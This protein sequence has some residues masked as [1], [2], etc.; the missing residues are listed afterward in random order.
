MKF[1]LILIPIGIS[2]VMAGGLIG[3][4]VFGTKGNNAQADA[5]PQWWRDRNRPRPLPSTSPT[6]SPDDGRGSLPQSGSIYA[7]SVF[8]KVTSVNSWNEVAF[9]PN[10]DGEF[11]TPIDGKIRHNDEGCYVVE[12]RREIYQFCGN[13]KTTFKEGEVTSFEP[14]GQFIKGEVIR[15]S[16]WVSS[17]RQEWQPSNLSK[18]SVENIFK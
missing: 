4:A 1:N 12:S 5:P 8:N 16:T 9:L 6:D 13:I 11:Y 15:V 17:G 18:E 14:I 10:E 2:L 3:A 7:G